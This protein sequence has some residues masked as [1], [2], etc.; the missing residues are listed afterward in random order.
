MATECSIGVVT[1][2]G[3]VISIIVHRDGYPEHV[4]P[5]LLSNYTTTDYVMQ[6]VALGE[7]ADLGTTINGS[8]ESC[9]AYH[10]D[11]NE[12]FC[13]YIQ[14]N[15]IDHKKFMC[16]NSVRHNYVFVDNRWYYFDRSG[17]VEFLD[18]HYAHI[19]EEDSV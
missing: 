5:I 17:T 1:S 19:Q 10:R 15:A 14:P 13:Q 18:A 3:A 7:L 12:E 16:N 9:V 11:R 8:A 2:N 4:A 6:L